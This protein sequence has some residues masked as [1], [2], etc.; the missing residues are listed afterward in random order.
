MEKW[1]DETNEMGLFLTYG[2]LAHGWLE[3]VT[4][5]TYLIHYITDLTQDEYAMGLTE[6]STYIRV[7]D[8][9]LE[10]LFITPE[11]EESISKLKLG[12][13]LDKLPPIPWLPGSCGPE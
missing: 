13:S 9:T 5:V 7:Y 3:H 8:E 2:Q 11:A 10:F 1:N 4:G 6:P 12:V